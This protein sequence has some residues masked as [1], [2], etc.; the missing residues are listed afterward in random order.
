[1]ENSNLYD[2]DYQQIFYTDTGE[3]DR[4]RMIYKECKDFSI[5]HSES[6]NSAYDNLYKA[7]VLTEG[8]W[9]FNCLTTGNG[10]FIRVVPRDKLIN[11]RD[12]ITALDFQV[13]VTAD[14]QEKTSNKYSC[15]KADKTGDC[16]LGK[17]IHIL[18]DDLHT[19][20]S[21]DIPACGAFM[22][23]ERTIDHKNLFIEGKEAEFFGDEKELETKIKFYLKNDEKRKDIARKAYNKCRSSDYSH[24][25]K[26]KEIINLTNKL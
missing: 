2:L 9:L 26:I 15:N 24:T 4:D 17:T 5:N 23:A 1:M 16:Y 21:V 25:K 11:A 8:D 3:I 18:N 12:T 14:V 19:S 10:G 13:P 7:F 20:R 6:L 22:L